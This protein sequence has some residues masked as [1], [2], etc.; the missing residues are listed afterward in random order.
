MSS[1]KKEK[2][3]RSKEPLTDKES[4]RKLIIR[5]VLLGVA[6]IV[7]VVAFS[8]AMKAYLHKDPGYYKIDA[9]RVADAL[10]YSHGIELTCYFDGSSDEI[11]TSINEVRSAYSAALARLYKLLDPVNTYEGFKNLAYL[12]QHPGEDVEIDAELFEILNSAYALTVN[13]R[14]NMFAGAL[15][16]EWQGISVLQE[17]ADFDPLLNPDENERIA[18]IAACVGDLS[19]FTYKVVDPYEHIVRFDVSEAY[20]QFARDYELTAPVIDLAYLKEAYEIEYTASAVERTG[21]TNGYFVTDE[22]LSKAMSGVNE[23]AYVLHTLESGLAV[24]A[25]FAEL[26]GGMAICEARVFSLNESPLY[27]TIEKG[28]ETLFRHPHFDYAGGGTYDTL[29][30]A[31][32]ISYSGDI[33]SAAIDSYRLLSSAS[34]ADAA[35]YASG[36]AGEN[37]ALAYVLKAEPNTVYADAAHTGVFLTDEESVGTVKPIS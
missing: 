36:R 16:S 12:D 29:I 25:C 5:G 30:L 11:R 8:I 37:T 31:C 4:K 10:A 32:A 26:K 22:G 33:V 2:K 7:A 28:G 13:G 24:R 1:D 9:D 15:Y 27:Y 35:E 3:K 19:N 18:A 17:Q 20:K 21:H 23:G 34:S 6:V 14:F